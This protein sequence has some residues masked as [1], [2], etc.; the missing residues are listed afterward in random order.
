MVGEGEESSEGDGSSDGD[1]VGA[2]AV[3]V[4]VSSA[5]CVSV[6]R[7]STVRVAS[8]SGKTP[9]TTPTTLTTLHNAKNATVQMAVNI[10]VLLPRCGISSP[11]LFQ[12]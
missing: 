3:A 9:L 7:S 1:A 4:N 2:S 6:C 10:T 12:E 11:S 8:V 5:S